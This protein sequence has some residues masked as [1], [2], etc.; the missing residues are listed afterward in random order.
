MKNILEK[1][2]ANKRREVVERKKNFPIKRLEKNSNFNRTTFS[3]VRHLRKPDGVGII[4][5]FKRQSPSRGTINDESEVVKTTSGYVEAGVSCI[6]ILT[7]EKYFGGKNKDITKSRK[8][9]VSPILRK[10]F[11]IDEYQLVE[12]KSIGADAILLIAALLSKAEIQALATFS[13]NLG[14]EVLTEIHNEEEL[15]KLCPQVDIVGVNN[16][17]LKTFETSTDTSKYLSGLI[18]S[19]FL[20]ISESGIHSTESLL[21]LKSY[22]FEGFLIGER[23]MATSNPVEACRMFIDSVKSKLPRL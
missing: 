3:M 18:P 11:I 17:N 23:F 10:D 20:K 1:I 4:A 21:E 15:D 16:R 7:D 14:L 6:S 19:E 12:A 22:G 2:V 13:G 9:V 8:F 5:E